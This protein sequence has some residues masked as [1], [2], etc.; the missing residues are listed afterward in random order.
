MRTFIKRALLGV[1]VG[2]GIAL[3]G[4]GMAQAAETDG[5]DGLLSGTQILPS[6][7]VPITVGGNAISVLG[8]SSTNDAAASAPSGNASGETSEASTDGSDGAASGTQGI[9]SVTVPVTVGGNAISVVGDSDSTSATSAPAEPAEPEVAVNPQTSGE[10]GI[11]GGTQ[12]LVDATVPVTVGG[13]AISVLGDSESTD[14]DTTAP[15]GTGGTSDP[16]A[17]ETSGADATLGG[18]QVIA[19]VAVPVTVGGNAISV[20]GDS[21]STDAD[22]TAPADTAGTSDPGEPETTGNDGILGGTQ[23]IAP[24]AAPVTAGGN[25]ISVLGD[26]TSTDA[27]TTAP[28]GT[29]SGTPMT[30]G[31]GGILGGT[32][33]AL[34]LSIPVT[35]GGNAVSVVGD[36]ETGGS[37]TP[38]GPGNPGD[39]GNP[40]NP[41][42]PGDPGNPVDPGQPGTP[43]TGGSGT[44]GGGQAAAL[45]VTGLASTG[46]T[47]PLWGIPAAALI[48]GL[49]AL[50]ASRRA[51]RR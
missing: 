7:E 18:T 46:G 26:S 20:L 45:S 47:A 44:T 11:L 2:G 15:T 30:S 25:A 38:A 40:G 1:V 24:V 14:A 31:Q 39:P 50:L 36:S 29:S 16:G 21:E 32:Q 27:D 37:T 4:A 34:P 17:P 5:D 19:P 51:A 23:A 35:L 28:A 6:I 33:V 9:V 41:G 43:G 13:N 3:A 42:D 22:T 48:A 12:G 49:A 10:D 8:D